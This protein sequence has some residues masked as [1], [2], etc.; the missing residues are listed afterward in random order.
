MSSAKLP[1]TVLM[2][3]DTAVWVLAVNRNLLKMGCDENALCAGNT[4]SFE[5]PLLVQAAWAPN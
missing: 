4:W 1:P 5:T 3:G 2:N